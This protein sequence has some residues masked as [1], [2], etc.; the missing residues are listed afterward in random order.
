MIDY[1]KGKTSCEICNK[2]YKSMKSLNVHISSSHKEMSPIEYYLKYLNIKSDGKCRFCGEMAQFKGFTKGFLNVCTNIKCI[3]KSFAPF[4]KEYK[5][6]IDGL[7]E[8]EYE[9]WKIENFKIKSENAKK[10]FEKKIENDPNFHRKNSRYCEEFWIKKGYSL[11]ESEE[12]SKFEIEKNRDILKKI[13]KDNPEYMRG[14][15]WTSKD[16]WIKKGYTLE[17]AESTVSEKQST[18]SLRKCI[19]KY[20]EEKGIEIWKSRQEKWIK[21]LDSKSDEEKME[22]LRK[23]TFAN[24]AYSNISQELFFSI[25]E[26]EMV[27]KKKCFFYLLNEE[28]IL[29]HGKDIFKPDFIYNNKIIEFFG[30]YWHANPKFYS[31]FEKKIRRGTKNYSVESIWKID[32]YR[33]NFFK[34]N[35][36]E[37]LVIWEEDYRKDKKTTIKKCIEF[38]NS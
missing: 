8:K 29:E 11:E 38:L 2:E 3:K 18:F 37:V 28:K 25:I 32:E 34:K 7:S 21:T 27:D 9:I 19:E 33:L 26:N 12:K 30:N 5:M 17:E 16:Y 36:Y 14:K 35:G 10:L 24:K 4:S 23:K 20:G 6:V 31:N 15:T 22:I 13:I 1:Q